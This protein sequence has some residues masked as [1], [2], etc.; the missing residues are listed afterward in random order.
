LDAGRAGA[1]GIE[2][3]GGCEVVLI[4]DVLRR[5]PTELT[6]R[7]LGIMNAVEDVCA[8]ET[9]VASV[10]GVSEIDDRCGSIAGEFGV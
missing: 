10:L 3:F 4:L 5:S 6:N 7:R 2:D 8:G 9:G 1:F